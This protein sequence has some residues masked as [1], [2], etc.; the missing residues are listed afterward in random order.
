MDAAGQASE[1]E[2]GISGNAP[3]LS[4][5]R[6]PAHAFSETVRRRE[7]ILTF[8]DKISGPGWAGIFPL[9]R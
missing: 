9:C 4:C 2:F 1:I 5:R 8:S 7:L 6:R 3:E